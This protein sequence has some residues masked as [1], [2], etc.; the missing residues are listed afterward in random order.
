L[1]LPDQD[2]HVIELDQLRGQKVVLAFYPGD[3]TPVCTGELTLIQEIQGRIKELGGRVVA[4][5][6]DT[7]DAHRAW[8]NQ[9]HFSFPLLSD[10]WPH[11]AVAR[12]YGTFL[13][14]RGITNRALF[15]VDGGGLVQDLWVAPTPEV[16]PAMTVIF[17]ALEGMRG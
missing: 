2:G 13:E 10:F 12:R 4:V 6:C 7:V 5:S 9:M 15:F 11:G 1:G 8:R 14:D 17:K 3:W 16:S